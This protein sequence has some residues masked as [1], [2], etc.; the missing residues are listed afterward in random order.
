MAVAK[1]KIKKLGK[2]TEA[3]RRAVAAW[4]A[5]QAEYIAKT[6]SDEFTKVGATEFNLHWT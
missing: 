6:P 2:L 3:Q 5:Q 1:L 4:L